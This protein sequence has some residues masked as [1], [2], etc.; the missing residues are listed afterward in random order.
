MYEPR[1]QAYSPGSDVILTDV[2]MRTMANFTKSEVGKANPSRRCPRSDGHWATYPSGAIDLFLSYA[3]AIRGIA[4]AAGSAPRKHGLAM[5]SLFD[6]VRDYEEIQSTLGPR[7]KSCDRWIRI[8][9]ADLTPDLSLSLPGRS[10]ACD[11]F[12]MAA[13]GPPTV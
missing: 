4:T 3:H 7:Q 10:R 8:A 1:R 6:M 5:R 11:W 9:G 12:G 13:T 2:G